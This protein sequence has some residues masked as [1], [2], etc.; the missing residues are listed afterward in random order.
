MLGCFSELPP[1][2]LA[3]RGSAH[4]DQTIAGRHPSGHEAA[5]EMPRGERFL[6]RMAVG[7]ESKRQC[8]PVAV[9]RADAERRERRASPAVIEEH[10]RANDTASS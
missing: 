5:V 6:K 8:A 7:R 9:L 4:R 1:L 10:S 3:L 2:L